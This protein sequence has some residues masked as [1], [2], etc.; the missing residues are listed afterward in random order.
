MFRREIERRI[1]QN[2]FIRDCNMGPRLLSNRAL[3][4]GFVSKDDQIISNF[5]F[6]DFIFAGGEN[7]SD[8]F[9]LRNS[10]RFQASFSWNFVLKESRKFSYFSHV[11]LGHVKLNSVT[12]QNEQDSRS[13]RSIRVLRRKRK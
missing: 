10:D 1:L 9:R 5:I 2:L 3:S 13:L 4:F 6:T 7:S 8:G 12:P 11:F